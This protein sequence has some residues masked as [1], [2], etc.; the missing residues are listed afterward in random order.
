M[1]RE[2]LGMRATEQSSAESRS[3]RAA[4]SNTLFPRRA[5]SSITKQ[6][7]QQHPHSPVYSFFPTPGS[8]ISTL[9]KYLA[10]ELF[11][12]IP[13]PA[14]PALLAAKLPHERAGTIPRPNILSKRLHGVSEE[15]RGKG[16]TNSA[17]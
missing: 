15:W 10:L 7:Q 6:Q 16:G 1:R 3:K 12:P 9:K 4:P 17:T 2:P 11:F 8:P 14:F 5:S 13:S